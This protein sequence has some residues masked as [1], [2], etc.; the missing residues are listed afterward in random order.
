MR[1]ARERLSEI[2]E[3]AVADVLSEVL[4]QSTGDGLC[5]I[6]RNLLHS[7]SFGAARG[8][9]RGDVEVH[10]SDRLIGRDP[11]V[12]PDSDAF[13]TL[14][15]VD[16]ASHINHVLHDGSAFVWVQVENRRTMLNRDHEY[17][18]PA[19]LFASHQDR[20]TFTTPEY[21]VRPA[22]R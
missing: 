3:L 12:L 18:G 10:M 21:D 5:R 6:Q 8:Q 20:G 15:S 2:P 9:G 22:A 11:V 4:T 19:T 14:D 13:G 17:M 16:S 7:T 1:R